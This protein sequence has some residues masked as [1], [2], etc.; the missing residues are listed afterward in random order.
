M[1]EEQESIPTRHCNICGEDLPET[2][3]YFYPSSLKGY[4]RSHHI[5]ECKK[6]HALR[7]RERALRRKLLRQG[8]EE[9]HVSQPRRKPK[10][11]PECCGACG[12]SQGNIVG[13][14][15]EATGTLYGYLCLKCYK[16]VQAFNADVTRLKQVQVYIQYTR[17]QK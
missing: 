6:C 9:K 13:D 3:D 5:H 15:E 2:V 8:G 10:G 11:T 4:S 12:K 14:G 16:L 1:D 7:D 17:K